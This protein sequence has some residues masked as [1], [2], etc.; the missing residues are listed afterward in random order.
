MTGV[1]TCALPI[2]PVLDYAEAAA[3][4]HN[5]RR[6][7]FLRTREGDGWEP[8]RVRWGGSGEG[9]GDVCQVSYA[10]TV[11]RTL[12]RC[13]DEIGVEKG[14]V[15][16]LGAYNALSFA[17]TLLAPFLTFFALHRQRVPACARRALWLALATLV[18]E[19]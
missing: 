12:V 5:A 3:H 7:T 4:P 8:V 9:G 10:E 2:F 15:V 6:G 11:L 19:Y 14:L 13:R 17:C 1:R 16:P 18:E